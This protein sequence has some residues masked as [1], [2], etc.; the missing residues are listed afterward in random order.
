MRKWRRYILS[1]AKDLAAKQLERH[2]V[3]GNHLPNHL[4]HRLH[5]SIEGAVEGKPAPQ[6]MREPVA[7]TDPE[8]RQYSKDSQ[9]R[10]FRGGGV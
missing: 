3:G 9:R 10:P 5:K 7:V 1:Q 6:K 4:I 2:Q 8:T